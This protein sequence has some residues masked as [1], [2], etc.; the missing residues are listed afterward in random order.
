MSNNVKK[1]LEMD[2]NA[3]V[4]LSR[5]ENIDSLRSVVKSLANT[6]NRRIREL[7]SDEVGKFSPAYARL[8]DSGIN[9]FNTKAYS[10]MGTNKLMEEFRTL[11]KFLTAKTSTVSG[12]KKVRIK[13]GERT[14][15]K[16]LFGIERKSARSAAIWQNREK[17]FWQ[18]YNRLVDNFG[19]IITQLDSNR[20]QEMLSKIQL[21]RNQAKSDDDISMAMTVYID[22]LYRDKEFN[23]DAYADALKTAEYMEEVR[24]AYEKRSQH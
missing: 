9:K 23:D 3:I 11:K 18:L 1:L 19:A 20:I 7:T 8:K 2:Y 10:E 17:R 4:E 13:I 12:W 22:N 14:G 5:K 21:K 16:K 24:L 6:A 15:A